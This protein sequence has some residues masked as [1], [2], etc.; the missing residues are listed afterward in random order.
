MVND[1]KWVE[2]RFNPDLHVSVLESSLPLSAP[3]HHVY[4]RDVVL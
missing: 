3:I 1:D 2:F 4:A